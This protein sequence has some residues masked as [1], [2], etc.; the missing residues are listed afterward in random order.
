MTDWQVATANPEEHLHWLQ[1]YA[2][3]LRDTL[4][5]ANNRRK[6]TLSQMTQTDWC[7][8]VTQEMQADL[9]YEQSEQDEMQTV[10]PV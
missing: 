4:R 5:K 6:E 1:F 7:I 2:Y 8:A 10:M 9:W 3:A